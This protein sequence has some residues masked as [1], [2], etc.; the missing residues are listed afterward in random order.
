MSTLVTLTEGKSHLKIT[1]PD[2]S[3]VDADVQFKLDAAEA[4]ILDYIGS[5]AFW[6]AVIVEWDA[7][8]VPVH[9]KQAILLQLGEYWRGRGD[10]LESPPRDASLEAKDFSPAIVGLLRRTRDPVVR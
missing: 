10:D 6:E 3:A 7:S 9:V 1:D 4:A 5:T 8:T 2:G